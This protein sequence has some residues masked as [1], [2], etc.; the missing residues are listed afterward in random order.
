M[1]DY[2]RPSLGFT[3]SALMEKSLGTLQGSTSSILSEGHNFTKTPSLGAKLGRKLAKRALDI[4]TKGISKIAKKLDPRKVVDRLDPRNF[5]KDVKRVAKLGKKIG[6]KH[7]DVAKKVGKAGI[8]AAKKGFDVAKKVFD[9]FGL[10]GKDKYEKK[11]RG[12]RERVRQ[13][14]QSGPEGKGS[15]YQAT[16]VR[17]AFRKGTY[18]VQRARR[19]G[20][21]AQRTAKAG[22][23]SKSEIKSIKQSRRASVDIA[24]KRRAGRV[25]SVRAG[26]QARKNTV[27]FAVPKKVY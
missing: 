18:D 27:A 23:A 2:G 16:A 17:K 12:T 7:L 20:F 13:R 22:G 3:P 11:P 4:P 9:P 5:P 1:E 26:R 15:H 6:E 21:E 14:S 24:Q 8:G 25:A 10:F 19:A